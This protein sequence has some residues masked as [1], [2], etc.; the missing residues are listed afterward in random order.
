MEI[1][2]YVVDAF[3]EK[4]FSGN[5]AAVCPLSEWPDD[6]TLQS[7]ASENNLSETAFFVRENDHYSL[8]WFTP[9]VE[10]NLCGHATLASAHVL[11]NHLN[12]S[13][14]ALHFNS[15][16]GRLVVKKEQ[17]FL[18]MD[19]PVNNPSRIS[20]PSQLVRGLGSQPIEV[21]QSQDTYLAVYENEEDVLS[22]SPDF[23]IIEQLDVPYIIITA[24]GKSSDFVSR[25]FAPQVGVPEDPVTGS[26]H[27]S[28]IPYWAETLG[29]NILHAIQVSKR[30]GVL[31]C[32]YCDDRVKIGGKAVTYSSGSIYID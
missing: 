10:V 4:V 17:D 7:I 3:T 23:G 32:E 24:K 15:K 20:S 2:I 5:P 16:S 1:L 12:Y 18:Q 26:A 19:F 14:S 27:C 22:V 25:F 29:K 31:Y 13:E 8:R 28:L 9:K 21:L 11:F 30:Q 6:K